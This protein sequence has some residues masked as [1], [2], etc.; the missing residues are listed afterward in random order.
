MVSKVKEYLDSG[1]G[2]YFVVAGSA[3]MVGDK[4]IVGLLRADGYTVTQK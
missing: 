4:G 1:S 3:H 2:T